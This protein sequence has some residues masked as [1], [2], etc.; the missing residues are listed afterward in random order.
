MALFGGDKKKAAE[1]KLI[2][3]F[4]NSFVTKNFMDY[5]DEVFSSEGNEWLTLPQNYYDK[6]TREV[7]FGPDIFEIKW[8]DTHNESYYAGDK[9]VTRKV[10]DIYGRV[11]VS[12]TASGY[13][14]LHRSQIDDVV[15]DVKKVIEVWANYIRGK[16]IEKYPELDF[17][18]NVAASGPDIL[19]R[20]TYNVPELSLHD[21]FS[22]DF[23]PCKSTDTIKINVAAPKVEE[24]V[25][26]GVS[27]ESTKRAN[28]FG[29]QRQDA[30]Q[31]ILK[32]EAEKEQN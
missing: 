19:W 18:I 6:R 21:W 25:D 26:E 15:F 12:F 11:A 13:K 5:I 2:E 9:L 31:Y 10:E 23:S 27:M 7:S 17:R 1:E 29:N 28:P 4:E 22:D 30:V 32:H 3:A 24:P 8:Y 20:L 16:L 14:P